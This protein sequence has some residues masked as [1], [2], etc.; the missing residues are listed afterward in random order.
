MAVLAENLRF[1]Q[2]FA[3]GNFA[4]GLPMWIDIQNLA[5]VRFDDGAGTSVPKKMPPY[6][7]VPNIALTS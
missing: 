1:G 6:V 5:G 7:P 3:D 2:D 4:P